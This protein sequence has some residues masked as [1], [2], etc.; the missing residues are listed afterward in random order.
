MS[1]TRTV[2]IIEDSD[3]EYDV[4]KAQLERFAAESEKY[5]FECVRFNDAES[6]LQYYKPMYDL[7][8]MDIGL[9]DMNGLEAT[10]RL[11]EMDDKVLLMF[12]TNMSKFAVSGYE[13]GAFDFVVK[14]I[15]YASLRLKLL[16]AMDKL[17]TD[18]DKKICVPFSGEDA[19][20]SAKIISASTIKYVE[21]MDHSIIIHTTSGDINTYGT[22]KKIENMLQSD[23]FCKC[24]SCYLVNLKYVRQIKDFTVI[25]ADDEI[26]VSHAKKKEFLRALGAYI[27]GT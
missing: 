18:E 13:V 20:G 8:F 19:R 26:S 2:A 15:K 11:R 1:I 17:D 14:P 16:H 9:P 22:L 25:V 7:I 24:N 10:R 21:V 12:I 3:G 27:K 5:A 6:F 4:L 23:S